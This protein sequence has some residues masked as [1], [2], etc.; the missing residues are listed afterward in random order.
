MCIVK[1]TLEHGLL[2]VA[3]DSITAGRERFCEQHDNEWIHILHEAEDTLYAQLQVARVIAREVIAIRIPNVNERNSFV[4]AFVQTWK[5]HF[6]KASECVTL[7]NR[8]VRDLKDHPEETDVL[9]VGDEGY[10]PAMGET[11]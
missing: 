3:L 10:V 11:E 5:F 1:D 6:E 2:F 4:T 9:G 8:L 7:C